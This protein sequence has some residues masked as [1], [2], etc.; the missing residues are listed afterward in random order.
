L[1]D[2]FKITDISLSEK[3]FGKTLSTRLECF[4]GKPR[5][6]LIGRGRWRYWSKSEEGDCSEP[7]CDGSSGMSQVL[8]LETLDEKGRLTSLDEWPDQE[9]KEVVVVPSRSSFLGGQSNQ[10]TFD[11]N[12]SIGD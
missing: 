4:L 2:S 6:G 7:I 10:I 3:S 12:N 9:A 8:N 11:T 1:I 5:D